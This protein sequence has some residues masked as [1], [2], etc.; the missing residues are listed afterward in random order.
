MIDGWWLVIGDWRLVICA[1]LAVWMVNGLNGLWASDQEE[2][3]LSNLSRSQASRWWRIEDWWIRD[4]RL[5]MG[6]ENWGL[7]IRRWMMNELLYL[8]CLVSMLDTDSASESDTEYWILFLLNPN[9]DWFIQIRILSCRWFFGEGRV[10]DAV[11]R[12]GSIRSAVSN[13][14]Y[15]RYYMSP[16]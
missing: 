3:K 8:P 1:P 11:S 14:N 13:T 6:I 12:V 4:W 7:R 2:L 16:K 9:T 5:G 10:A 15:H